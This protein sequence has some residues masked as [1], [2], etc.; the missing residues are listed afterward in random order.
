MNQNA[1]LLPDEVAAAARQAADILFAALSPARARDP[2]SPGL[3]ALWDITKML[4]ALSGGLD[5][6]RDV[7]DDGPHR[8]Q[9]YE[10]LLQ[11][12]G[13]ANRALTQ[14]AADLTP[15]Q[16]A[17]G[18]RKGTPLARAWKPSEPAGPS[19]SSAPTSWR[20]TEP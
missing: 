18:W 3:S 4:N 7:P 2:E 8:S 11:A 20:P 1:A 15:G 12:E 10:T 19:S 14:I 5:G 6:F 13:I 9:W 17:G 16:A